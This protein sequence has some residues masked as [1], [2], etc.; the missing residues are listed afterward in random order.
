MNEQL[1]GFPLPEK[2]PSDKYERYQKLMSEII[3][4]AQSIQSSVNANTEAFH[5]NEEQYR[6]QHQ[7]IHQK[8]VQLRS[9]MGRAIPFLEQW[10][11][12]LDLQ[13]VAY[14]TNLE[15]IA[16]MG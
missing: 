2:W 6:D 10:E 1:N 5:S 14:R 9:K 12:E 15:D 11:N 13:E 8:V 4:L 3:D 16:T 7:E